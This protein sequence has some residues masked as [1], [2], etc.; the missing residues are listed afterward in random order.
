M[1]LSHP[2]Q[3]ELRVI[4]RAKQGGHN[5]PLY[6]I[7]ANFYGNLV[8]LNKYYKLFDEII[9]IDTS[10]SLQHQILLHKRRLEILFYTQMKDQPEWFRKFLPN[11]A[12]LVLK[13]ENS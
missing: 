6:E 8:T 4:D 5:V 2:H 13:K 10:K 1:G 3:S 9:I 12:K 7:N 11:L